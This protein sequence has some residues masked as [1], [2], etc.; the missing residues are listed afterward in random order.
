MTALAF[1]VAVAVGATSDGDL[2]GWVIPGATVIAALLGATALVI[3]R[4]VRGPVAIQD[5]W[6]ENRLQRTEMTA[7]NLRVDALVSG[8]ESDRNIIRIISEGFRALS[9]VVDRQVHNGVQPKIF[10]DE[11]KAIERARAV[12]DDDD[13]W[14]TLPAVPKPTPPKE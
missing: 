12:V 7:M 1:V 14:N 9:D 5:L 11:E 4:K 6:A 13:L 2:P 3:V 8:R 10:P